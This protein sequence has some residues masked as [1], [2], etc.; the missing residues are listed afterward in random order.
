MDVR[1]GSWQPRSTEDFTCRF[2]CRKL[3]VGAEDC[4]SVRRPSPLLENAAG[5]GIL[6][7]GIEIPFWLGLRQSG[8]DL[9]LDDGTVVHRAIGFSPERKYG[10]M[11]APYLSRSGALFSRNPA[12][13]LPLVLEW[14]SGDI[15]CGETM[16]RAGGA[17]R[18]LR[19]SKLRTSACRRVFCSSR[20]LRSVPRG[21]RFR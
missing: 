14:P 8:R 4:G 10:C 13:R 15:P 20:S 18:N 21:F 12:I 3:C 7:R 11:F 6:M 17:G 19:T 1:C 5:A 2:P 16:I 9:I